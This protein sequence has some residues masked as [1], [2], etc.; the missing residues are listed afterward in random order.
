[1]S[2]QALWLYERKGLLQ[3]DR[4]TG[5]TRRYSDTDITRLRRI[6]ELIDDGINLVGVARVLGL[7]DDNTAIRGDNHALRNDNTVLRA[8]NSRL[9]T[10]N[11]AL[12]ASG[13]V[14]PSPPDPAESADP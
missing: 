1:M 14:R 5:G 4:T 11:A 13:P 3:P 8:Q 2:A 12:R 7:E 9:A 6:S 10:D